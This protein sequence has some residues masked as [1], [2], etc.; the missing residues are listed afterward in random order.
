MTKRVSIKDIAEVVGV[1]HSTVSRALHGRGRMSDETRRQILETAKELGYT[2]DA[3]ARSLVQGTTRTVGVVVTSIADPFVIDIVAGIED[4]TQKAGYSVFL[5]A[6][7][8]DPVREMAVVETFRERRVDA[9]I[10]T[11]SRVGNLYADLLEDFGAPIVL[12][13]NMQEGRYLHSVSA[14]DVAGAQMA[15]ESLLAWGHRRI[16]FIGSGERSVSSQ[17]RWRGY[18]QAFLARGLEPP[19]GLKTTPEVETD[20]EAGRRG[21]TALLPHGPTAIFAYN[22]LTAIGVMLAA[23]ELRLAIPEQLSLVGFDDIQAAQFVTPPLTTVR[24]PR[25]AMGRAAME[26]ALALLQDEEPRNILF[27]CHLVQRES[28]AAP[29]GTEA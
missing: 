20:L 27:P 3:R 12:I 16:G 10:V 7:H 25:K 24:Q 6:S 2:P 9:V 19:T 13:N 8:K 1:S 29:A 23:R 11:A 26:M 14:D 21:L 17:R 28:V 15:V 4:V 22:D 5:S 18:C